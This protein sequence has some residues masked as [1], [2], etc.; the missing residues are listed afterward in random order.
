MILG[1]RVSKAGVLSGI[2]LV[3]T[4]HY[5]VASL[6]PVLSLPT[7]IGIRTSG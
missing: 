3:L 6:S 5:Q 2:S 4:L 7:F 1:L